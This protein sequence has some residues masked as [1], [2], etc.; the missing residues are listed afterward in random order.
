MNTCIDSSIRKIGENI[1]NSESF[2][3]LLEFEKPLAPLTTMHVG[4]SAELFVEPFNAESLIETLKIIFAQNTPRV[5]L[6][7]LGGG[8]NVIAPD[9]G[10]KGI[11][12][13][14]RK[15]TKVTLQNGKIIPFKMEAFSEFD[16]ALCVDIFCESGVLVDFLTDFC[17][18]NGILGLEKFAGLP[19]TVGGATWMNARCYEKNFSS[20]IQAV[21]YIDLSKNN[22]AVQTY[23][24]L[25]SDW[26]YKKS[27]FQEKNCF[28]TGVHLLGKKPNA[29]EKRQKSIQDYIKE[30]N[31][32]YR[33]DRKQKGHFKAFS[34]GSAFKNNRN[35]GKPSGKLIDEAGLRGKSIGGAQIAPWHGNFI[36]NTGSATAKDIKSL[37][38]HTQ[39]QILE[40]TGFL[41]EPEI[42]FLDENL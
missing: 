13:S 18:E 36:I 2:V 25:D 29:Q 11:T 34:A 24:M 30:Q 9:K 41:L 39:K 22:F 14:S 28:I 38:E 27:P 1:N 3:G 4:G 31:E 40:K 8:S 35:F 33:N 5:P 19:G 21:D 32:F 16:S 17:A 37:V 12:I 10:I 15:M 42:I 26:D 6:T 23:N 20:I 7:I